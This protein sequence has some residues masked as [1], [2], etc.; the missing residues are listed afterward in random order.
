ME[1]AGPLTNHRG[2][3][4]PL[5]RLP[6]RLQ[7][8]QRAG[9][10]PR[11]P[12]LPGGGQVAQHDKSRWKQAWPMEPQGT[13]GCRGSGRCPNLLGSH[14]QTWGCRCLGLAWLGAAFRIGDGYLGF[15]P[16]T[17]CDGIRCAAPLLVTVWSLVTTSKP[18]RAGREIG[19]LALC[20]R[21]IRGR[22]HAALLSLFCEPGP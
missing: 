4:P 11:W 19:V 9:L 2:G 5:Q 1:K 17:K 15:P 3:H 20:W 8:E 7:L 10:A 14:Y 6:S 22:A 18:Q 21:L 16:D 12:P 13:L